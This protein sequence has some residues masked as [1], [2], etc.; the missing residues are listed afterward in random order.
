MGEV[1]YDKSEE[2]LIGTYRD[3]FWVLLRRSPVRRLMTL[4]AVCSMLL[5]AGYALNRAD[6]GSGWSLYGAAGGVV[7]VLPICWAVSYALLPGRARK[8]YRQ[9]RTVDPSY[10]W[11]WSQ[12][13]LESSN[14]TGEN[15]YRWSGMHRWHDGRRSLMFFLN[16]A[17]VLYIPLRVL[18][19][20]QAEEIRALA[21]AGMT[22]RL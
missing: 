5:L 1:T 10:T 16:D 12:E 3:W 7:L 21:H 11:R 22:P 19:A 13:G 14:A 15:R 9:Q 20:E 6:E 8:L 18:S 4:A 2:D 17:F